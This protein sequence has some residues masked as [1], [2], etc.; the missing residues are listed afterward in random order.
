MVA[1]ACSLSTQETEAGSPRFQG[2]LD[3]VVTSYL[4]KNSDLISKPSSDVCLLS[5]GA[6]GP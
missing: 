4:K 6:A 2:S 1:H 3:Y 5:E